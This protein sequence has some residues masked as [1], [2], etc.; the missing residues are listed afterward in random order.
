MSNLKPV[1][2]LF[3]AL[4]A[5]KPTTIG[6]EQG[7]DQQATNAAAVLPPAIRDSRVYRCKD[8]SLVYVDFL[9]D[10]RTVNLRTKQEGPNVTLTSSDQGKSFS[11][12]GYEVEG[13]G[14][15]ITLHSPDG[16]SQQCKS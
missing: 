9:A 16:P 15:S 8:N 5:C 11:G 4:A 7:N 6:G 10:S 1:L 13:S 2:C 3:L 14:P 12:S